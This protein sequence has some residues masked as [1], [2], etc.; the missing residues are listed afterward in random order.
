MKKFLLLFALSSIMM[1]GCHNNNNGGGSQGEGD[2]TVKYYLDFNALAMND[3]YEEVLVFNNS[4]LKEPKR[5]TAEQAPLP[6]FPVFK[7][8]STKEV[9]D[10]DSDLWNFATDKVNVDSGTTE[11]RLYG[12]WA[13]EGE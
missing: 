13:S 2:I 12:F 6:E 11:F 10:D 7:G 9:I 3:I 8:W 4:K 5:P 1:V